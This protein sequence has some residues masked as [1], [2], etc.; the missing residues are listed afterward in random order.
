MWRMADG[1]WSPVTCRATPRQRR[2]CNKGLSSII[3]T[4][5]AVC[6]FRCIFKPATRGSGP[7]EG[8]ADVVLASLAPRQ[9]LPWLSTRIEARGGR[10]LGSE[11]PSLEPDRIPETTLHGVNPPAPGS[12]D[13]SAMSTTVKRASPE[14][15]PWRMFLRVV[16]VTV[17]VFFRRVVRRK[18]KVVR[19]S[20]PFPCPQPSLLQILATPAPVAPE[21]T[22]SVRAAANSRAPFLCVPSLVARPFLPPAV[23]PQSHR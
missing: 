4:L 2:T 18:R 6:P 10:S 14:I 11:A 21:N 16:R 15:P 9:L 12:T 23:D 7:A 20:L 5:F 3:H 19:R 13:C 17:G 22:F 8:R 1:G